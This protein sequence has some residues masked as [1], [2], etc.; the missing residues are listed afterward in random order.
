MRSRFPITTLLPVLLA[1][2]QVAA[3][4]TEGEPVVTAALPSL[5][6]CLEHLEAD[7]LTRGDGGNA[8]D[9]L[10]PHLDRDHSDQDALALLHAIIERYQQLV[11]LRLMRQ[12]H[13]RVAPLAEALIRVNEFR[14]RII[15][16]RIASGAVVAEP[17][18]TF[19]ELLPHIEQ[20]QLLQLQ[21]DTLTAR[22]S[23]LEQ[24]LDELS[25]RMADGAGLNDD[26]LMPRTITHHTAGEGEAAATQPVGAGVSTAGSGVATPPAASGEGGEVQ[27]E[28]GQEA[29]AAID[30]SAAAAGSVEGGAQ[31]DEEVPAA[32]A[33]Q[34]AAGSP[35]AEAPP[36]INMVNEQRP[37][38]P[39]PDEP[40]PAS[41]LPAT[42]L[43]TDPPLPTESQPDS[44]SLFSQQFREC[45]D[46]FNM[47]DGKEWKGVYECYQKRLREV[48]EQ[49]RLVELGQQ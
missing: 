11:N 46:A 1:V 38:T 21:L 18:V 25:D 5:T 31:P 49:G 48:I 20:Q 2:G 35:S 9:C 8:F 43:A 40:E 29:V 15:R 24:Q 37:A 17:A 27:P 7:R 23:E 22:I 14:N 34:E 45:R 44:R 42:A 13:E 30:Q 12:Q 47:S 26:P 28:P 16:E 3:A 36:P 32:G 6:L 39:T 41:Q 33:G 19:N 4:S 10:V